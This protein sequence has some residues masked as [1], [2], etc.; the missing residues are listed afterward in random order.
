MGGALGY[1]VTSSETH[2]TSQTVEVN[3]GG[4]VEMH[5]TIKS[6]HDGW[7]L[8]E[9]DVWYDDDLGPGESRDPRYDYAVITS[10]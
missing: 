5:H 7:H 1:T 6:D 4:C 2:S 9:D 3:G 10:C 8:W